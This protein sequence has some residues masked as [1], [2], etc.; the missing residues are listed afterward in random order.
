MNTTPSVN[1]PT[2]PIMKG[3]EVTSSDF[4]ALATA[5]G[6]LKE[7]VQRISDNTYHDISLGKGRH[8]ILSAA[9]T[10]GGAGGTVA[11]GEGEIVVSDG[12][13]GNRY[14]NTRMNGTIFAAALT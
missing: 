8:Q 12:G 14:L 1:L 13:G 2:T 3:T 7:E 5:I 6:K 10:S 11:I 9:P 4:Q